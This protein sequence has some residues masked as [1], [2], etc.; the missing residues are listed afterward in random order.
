MVQAE[1]LA[2]ENDI[3]RAARFDK[4]YYFVGNSGRGSSLAK[5]I[6]PLIQKIC[7]EEMDFLYP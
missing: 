7:K 5:T 6:D 2:Y 1:R 3:R 4:N